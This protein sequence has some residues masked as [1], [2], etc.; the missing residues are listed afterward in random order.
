MSYLVTA[1][2][3]RP[4]DFLSVAGQQHVTRT[5]ANAIKRERIAH[6]YLFAGPRG[7]GKTSIARILAKALNCERGP[8]SEPCL[9]CANCQEIT[10]GRNIAVREIDGASHNSVDN[11]RE[12]IDSFRALP[13][14]GSRYKVYIIDEVHMLS[15]AAFNALLKSLEEPPP[16]TVFILA[17]TE[18]HKIPE[19]VIS[20]CQ[21]FDFR[22]LP[23]DVVVDRLGQIAAAEKVEVEPEVLRLIARLSEGSMR[24]AQSLFDRVHAFCEGTMTL[25]EASQVLGVVDRVALGKLATAVV[26]RDPSEALLILQG[27]F[28][29]GVDPVLFLRDL[30]A[31]F[32][33]LV[34]ARLAD[35]KAARESGLTGEDLVELRRLGVALSPHDVQDL[36]RLVSDGCDVALRSSYPRYMLEALIVRL[37]TREKVQDLQELLTLLKSGGGQARGASAA[38]DAGPRPATVKP[39]PSRAAT[40]VPPAAPAPRLGEPLPWERFVDVVG[41]KGSRVLFEHLKR[42]SIKEFSRGVLEATGPAFSVSSLKERDTQKKLLQLLQSYSQVDVWRVQFDIAESETKSLPGSLADEEDRQQDVRRQEVEDRL[43]QHPK[44]QSLQ[45]AFP[46]STIERIDIED[47]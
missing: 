28:S 32:R 11:V 16:N 42:L 14:P 27:V 18:V 30:T 25:G 12:L 29:S 23:G 36:F 17:T 31:F 7:V 3:F 41:E 44:I 34:I 20:R 19:T 40:P 21:R 26:R 46:G 39:L 43:A 33:D 4:G 9:Q 1:R 6:A 8:T 24:D 35:D 10:Q 45:K 5:L 15:T 13:P 38:V 47:T 22:A 2:K 37:A